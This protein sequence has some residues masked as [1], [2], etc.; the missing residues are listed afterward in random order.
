M[1][2]SIFFLIILAGCSSGEKVTVIKGP[3]EANSSLMVGFN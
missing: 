2:L 3:G 1:V